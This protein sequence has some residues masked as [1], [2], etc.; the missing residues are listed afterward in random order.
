MTWQG[1]VSPTLSWNGDSVKEVQAAAGAQCACQGTGTH[2]HPESVG[3]ETNVM[4]LEK[5]L[6][7]DVKDRIESC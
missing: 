3:M 5:R 2:C 6:L 1:M 4:G 7:E